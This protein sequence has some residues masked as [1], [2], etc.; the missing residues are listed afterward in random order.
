MGLWTPIISCAMVIRGEQG[1]TRETQGI[2][3]GVDSLSGSSSS[4]NMCKRSLWSRRGGFAGEEGDCQCGVTGWVGLEGRC[5]SLSFARDGACAV[6]LW[7]LELGLGVLR[8]PESVAGWRG[9]GACEQ[10]CLYG[11]G[12]ALEGTGVVRPLWR[13]WELDKAVDMRLEMV[14]GLWSAFGSLKCGGFCR[15]RVEIFESRLIIALILKPRL[16]RWCASRSV[17]S[18]GPH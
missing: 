13:G 4:V 16:Y 8:C 18:C 2:F 14:C 15:R 12:L 6:E 10:E 5:G 17:H 9:Y 11:C 1:G 3:L 7:F